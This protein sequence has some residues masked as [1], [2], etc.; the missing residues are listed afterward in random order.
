MSKEGSGATHPSI[1][2]IESVDD[3]ILNV[4]HQNIRKDMSRH[5]IALW[6][7]WG[8]LILL[9]I[10]FVAPISIYFISR[11]STSLTVSDLKDL[12][13]AFSGALAGLTGILGFVVGYYFKEES[14]LE[15][16]RPKK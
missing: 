15:T 6:F 14:R 10:T 12:L 11:P 4:K 8:Y 9:T 5:R 16:I 7:I 13:Q 3:N 2:T 1:Q